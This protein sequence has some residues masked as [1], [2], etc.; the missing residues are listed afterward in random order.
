PNETCCLGTRRVVRIEPGEG[1]QLVTGKIP[2][3]DAVLRVSS[4]ASQGFEL[5]CPTLFGGSMRLPDDKSVPMSQVAATGTCTV[6]NSKL[7]ATPTSKVI[8]LRAGTA[9]LLPWP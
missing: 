6:V 4:A 9:T 7:G 8:T 3:K 1:P 2:F 5:S